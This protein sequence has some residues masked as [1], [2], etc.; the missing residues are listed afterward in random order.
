MGAARCKEGEKLARS[1]LPS[2]APSSL[3]PG[4]SMDCTWK[5]SG[6]CTD[7]CTRKGA[8]FGGSR[9]PPGPSVWVW[10][11]NGSTQH[12]G[13]IRGQTCRR[14]LC[15]PMGLME[16]GAWSRNGA[17][18]RTVRE[19]WYLWPHRVLYPDHGD[20]GQL[21][22]DLVLAV[23]VGLGVGGEVAEGQADGPQP[24][25]RHGLDHLLHHLVPVL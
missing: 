2:P 1:V 6:L 19:L 8:G 17:G 14:C 13:A 7:P 22:Q 12:P 25:A 24:V 15:F 10:E 18:R 4:I 5:E 11:G 3:L 21:G 20:A 9:M 23:P 16:K